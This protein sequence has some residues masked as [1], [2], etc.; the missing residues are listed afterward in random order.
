MRKLSRQEVIRKCIV[1]F[2]AIRRMTSRGGAGLEPERGAEDEF[3]M[4]D[5]CTEQLREILR[6]MNENERNRALQKQV[7]ERYERRILRCAQDDTKGERIL[8]FAQD[9]TKGAQDD[10]GDMK[11][12]QKD[13]AGGPPE[14]LVF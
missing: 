7:E 8:R 2:E 1:V 6:E 14:R 10:N 4:I 5:D 3:Y 9:D 12:W 13:A 11:D